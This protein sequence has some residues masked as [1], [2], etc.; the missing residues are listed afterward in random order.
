M[1]LFSRPCLAASFLFLAI[2]RSAAADDALAPSLGKADEKDPIVWYDIRHLGVEGQ[3]WTDLKAPFDRLPAKAEK[4]VRSP[5]WFLSRHS[6]GL[7]VR[8][9][10]ESPAIHAR[11]TLTSDR[12]EMPHMPAT[13]SAASIST[14]RVPRA[15]GT[16]SAPVSPAGKR[17]SDPWSV[18]CRRASGSIF[19]ISPSTTA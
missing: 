1:Y 19:S 3:G 5:V 14:Q 2:V 13:A 11:W 16:G 17:R 7:C 10:T 9:V 18:D 6:A 12:L 15:G 8:F 4:Q